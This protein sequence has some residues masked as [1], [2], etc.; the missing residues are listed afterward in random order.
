M[1][2][3]MRKNKAEVVSQNKDAVKSNSTSDLLVEVNANIK[4]NGKSEAE[5]GG[6]RRERRS[7]RR[8]RHQTPILSAFNDLE[9]VEFVT[10]LKKNVESNSTKN[11]TLA[12]LTKAADNRHVH[13]RTITPQVSTLIP[14]PNEIDV[15]KSIAWP[16]THINDMKAYLECGN[17]PL[18][19]AGQKIIV[20]GNGKYIV[21]GHHRWSG[22]AFCNLKCKISALDMIGIGVKNPFNALKSAQYEVASETGKVEVQTVTGTNLLF[23]K[24]ADLKKEVKTRILPEVL[25]YVKTKL[26]LTTDE[27]VQEYFWNNVKEMQRSN[28]PVKGASKRD[29]MPQTTKNFENTVAIGGMADTRAIRAPKGSWR[30][31]EI[32]ESEDED[33]DHDHDHD[34]DYE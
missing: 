24:E 9:Y 31:E 5:R 23:I 10:Q 7:E 25:A 1:S 29:F 34:H 8:E 27:A 11:A 6:W 17:T 14:T 32:E 13:V 18:S 30:T 26:G 4:V 22:L 33:H 20:A 15:S 28:M 12:E 2:L 3:N 21:D 16:L 19:V